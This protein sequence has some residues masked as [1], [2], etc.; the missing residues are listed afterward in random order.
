GLKTKDSTIEGSIKNLNVE[1]VKDEKTRNKVGLGFEV[2]I[3]FTGT[4]TG[5]NGELEFLDKREEKVHKRDIDLSKLEIERLTL[6]EEKANNHNIDYGLKVGTSG[7][8]GRVG[9][10]ELSTGL[11]NAI[12]N[13]EE[14]KQKQEMA[15]KDI[16]S[17]FKGIKSKIDNNRNSVSDEL[18]DIAYEEKRSLR[19]LSNYH[20]NGEYLVNKINEKSAKDNTERKLLAKEIGFNDLK[21]YEKLTDENISEYSEGFQRRYYELKEKG[22]ELRVAVDQHGNVYTFGDMSELEFKKALAREYG[23]HEE[24][25]KTEEGKL[26]GATPGN[27][28]SEYVINGSEEIEE[29]PKDDVSSMPSDAEVVSDNLIKDFYK[30]VWSTIKENVPAGLIT[31]DVYVSAKTLGKYVFK[32]AKLTA[33]QV[34]VLTVSVI[35]GLDEINKYVSCGT[36]YGDCDTLL[37]K[38][39]GDDVYRVS[40]GVATFVGVTQIGKDVYTVAIK[41]G[42]IVEIGKKI[43]DINELKAVL[44]GLKESGKKVLNKGKD[45]IQ[46]GL[47][48]DEIL[49]TGKEILKNNIRKGY[50]TVKKTLQSKIDDILSISKE[51]DVVILKNNISGELVSNNG[52][53]VS[54]DTKKYANQINDIIKNGDITGQKTEK[55]VNGLLRDNPNLVVYN[56]KYGGNKGIDHLVYNKKTG[57]YW[58]I[59]SKQIAKAKTLESGGIKLSESAA[60]NTRQLSENWI[61]AVANKL[62][63]NEREFLEKIIKNKNYRTAVMGVNK[64]TGEIIF[65]PLIIKNK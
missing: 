26:L 28:Y 59:D 62:P 61:E 6:K 36:L 63:E 22:E 29:L 42:K 15:S 30:K 19:E 48:S 64:K 39:L 14:F 60:Q 40:K 53:K 27:I 49:D 10:L 13:P 50:V 16:E 9:D 23:I 7:V 18:T 65:V 20:L 44:S 54:Y 17:T 43:T 52:Y 41:D 46:G 56:G 34:V 5:G 1:E 21:V 3:A 8:S 35:D 33:G 51:N 25:R 11:V 38:F 55:I 31:M 45:L 24:G 32:G 47:K 12:M 4:P 57:E 2:S 58:A 37:K